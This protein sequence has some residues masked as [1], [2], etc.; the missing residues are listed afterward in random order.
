MTA[1]V[2]IGQGVGNVVM[3][4]PMV[5]A[6]ADLYG[7]V[8]VLCASPGAVLL[9]GWS[10]VRKLFVTASEVAADPEVYEVAAR[11]VWSPL[12]WPPVEIRARDCVSP[13]PCDL[14]VTHESEA[15]MT[16]PRKLGFRGPMPDPHVETDTWDGDRADIWLCPG[17]GGDGSAW[18]RKLWPYWTGLTEALHGRGLEVGVLGAERDCGLD[19]GPAS[20]D[21][22]GKTS[23]RQA[24]GLLAETGVA[25]CVD[26][27][28][29][30]VAAAS[31]AQT[32]AIFGFTS[33]TKNRPLGPSVQVLSA[34]LHCQPCQMT[35]RELT[36]MEPLCIESVTVADVLGAMGLG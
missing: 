19:V 20:V 4:T 7:P 28:L 29:A 18:R 12:S 34:G 8:D 31:G 27:G 13:D 5:A 23:L 1:I 24:A 22:R 33:P 9:D 14:R 21:L 15:G 16:V 11:G 32:F 25:V 6:M 3:A 36:C 35:P 30:H 26:N 17:I 10:A 2:C